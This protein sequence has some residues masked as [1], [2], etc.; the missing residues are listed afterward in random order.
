MAL[1]DEISLELSAGTGGSGVVRWLKEFMQRHGKP[2]G[3][4]GGKG[5]DVYLRAVR[6][7][8]YLSHYRQNPVMVAG[9]GEPGARARREGKNGEDL[10]VDVPRGSFVTWQET[11]FTFDLIEEGQTIRILKGG[12]GGFGNAHFA[13]STNRSPREATKGKPGEAGTFVVEL[14]MIADVGF[15]GLP[16]VGKS[17]LLNALTNAKSNVANYHFT[18]L[19]PHLGAFNGYILADIPGLIEGAAEGKGLGHKFLR[20]VERTRILVHCVSAESMDPALDYRTIRAEL[21]RYSPKLTEKAELVLLTKCDEVSET[22]AK[23][24]QALLAEAAGKTV[25]T[26]SVLDDLTLKEFSTLLLKTLQ[27]D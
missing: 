14:R 13:S 19:E 27:S 23:E 16:N 21:E 1:V 11:G 25:Q 20:H 9:N 15:V 17:T 18:T 4:D 3:G 8:G 22:E 5:G 2:A 12:E 6:D 10:Y 26:V 24:K 7:I